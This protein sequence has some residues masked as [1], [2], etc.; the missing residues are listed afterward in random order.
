MRE[1]GVWMT[2]PAIIILAA[3]MGTRM[4]S[5]LPKVLHKVAGRSMLGHVLAVA[6]GLEPERVV[7]VHGPG[8]EGALVAEEAR[9]QA[10]DAALAEQAE[11]KGTGHAVMQ[12]MP[13]LEGFDGPVLVLYGDV[14]LLRAESLSP[15]LERLEAEPEVALAVLG[16]HAEDPGA[17]GRLVVSDDGAGL[18]AIVEAKDANPEQLKIDYCNSGVMAVRAGVLRQLLPQLSDDNAQGEYYLTD[19]VELARKA[20]AKVAH[21]QCAEEEVLGVNS[22]L[23]LA[24]VEKVMQNRLRE[25]A[26][27]NGATLIDPES[28]FFSFD[29]EIGRDVTIEPWVFFGPGVRIGDNV[30]ILAHCHFEGAEVE[31]GAIIGPFARLRP[32]AHIMA[33]AKVGNFVEVKN[34]TVKP[35]AKVNHLSY[36]GDA[37][38]GE[39]A[40]IGAGTITCNY[41]GFLKHRTVI[42]EGAFIGSN[43]ALVAPVTIGAGALVAAGSTITKDVPEDALA[44]ERA[45]ERLSEGWAARYRERKKREKE[46]RLQEQ[47]KK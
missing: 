30:T 7:V 27:M 46:R 47:G 17:Y 3:G 43:T 10:P 16:F 19:L 45:E 28:V 15:L 25:R 12:A 8:E 5:R 36:I 33:G 14:P 24:R 29:T 21:A 26:M 31:E 18:Q 41:D 40:N 11:R 39:R 4:K 32:G 34:A 6:K 42:G 44:I 38:V 1:S 13:A 2:N 35:G 20:G 22:R 37:E 23:E 9:R